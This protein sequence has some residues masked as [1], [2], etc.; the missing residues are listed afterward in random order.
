[1][2]NDLLAATLAHN[3]LLAYVR[4]AFPGYVISDHHRRIADA[5]MAVERGE[6]KR[7]ILQAPPRHGKSLLT[8]EYFPAWYLGRNPDRYIICSTYGQELADDFGRKVRNQLRGDEHRAIFP[9]CRLSEDS[10]SASRFGTE[11]GGAYF[12]L[13]VGAA[14]TGR[15]AHLLAIDDPIKSRE[16]AD[17]ELSRRRLKEWYASVAYTRLMPGGAIILMATRWHDDDLTGWVLREHGHEGWTVIDLPAISNDGALWPEMYD[18]DALSRIRRTIGEREWSALYMQQPMPDSGDFF[19]R[20]WF[21]RYKTPPKHLRIYGASDY[22]VTADGGD[23]TEHGVFGLC[24]EGNL[25]LLDWWSG[26]TSADVWIEMQLDLIDRWEPQVWIGEAGPIRRAVEPFLVRRMKERRSLCRLEWLA[27]SHDKPTRARSF[28]AMCS[29]G[30]VYLPLSASWPDRLIM[31]AIS[32]PVGVNDDMIDTCSLI[33]RYI[34]EARNARIPPAEPLKPKPG[35]AAHMLMLT[36][37]PER[38]SRYRSVMPK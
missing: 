30:L 18:I 26:Q 20:D 34:H 10:Q 14:A 8:S 3:H 35:T 12:A 9:Q 36:D 27:S 38:V 25:Y 1:M 7:L 16:E 6:I 28:Q 29:A 4:L 2:E 22:A 23:Y 24:P 32:F 11:Q 13:G 33:G 17:S 5:L 15:G 37:E 31:Q 19:K 21:R